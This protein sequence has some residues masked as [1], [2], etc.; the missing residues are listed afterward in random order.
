MEN[1]VEYSNTS[2]SDSNA[3]DMVAHLFMNMSINSRYYDEKSTIDY[4][5]SIVSNT[6]RQVEPK[7]YTVTAT[8]TYFVQA[9]NEDH[10]TRIVYEAL[11][12]NDM[13]NI[14]DNGEVSQDMVVQTGHHST[15]HKDYEYEI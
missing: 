6:G 3:L 7:V 14:L 12:G 11:L 13:S 8:G 10:A 1:T 4:I 2:L 15:I 9:H 5:K